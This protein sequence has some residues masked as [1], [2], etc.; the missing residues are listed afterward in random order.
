MMKLLCLDIPLNRRSNM[1]ITAATVHQIFDFIKNDLMY[2]EVL[3]MYFPKKHTRDDFRNSLW[4]YFFEHPE[5][6]IKAYNQKY[7]KYYYIS[8]I[9]NQV[10]SNTKNWI[11]CT[12]NEHKPILMDNLPEESEETNPFQQEDDFIERQIKNNKLK[13]IDKAIQHYLSLDPTLKPEM[14]MFIMHYKE[15]KT[16]REIQKI[17]FNLPLTDVY[18]YINSA[19]LRI[20]W[21]M[22]KHT[23]FTN[24]D[25]HI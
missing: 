10:N 8:I 5:P 1:F 24:N 14:D 12:Y 3:K 9:K 25:K 15:G 11:N 22:K 4:L 7:F 21:Y 20:I 16:M 19:K 17:M 18:R 23:D 2:E 6:V 13:A